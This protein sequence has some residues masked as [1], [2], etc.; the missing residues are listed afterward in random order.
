MFFTSTLTPSAC[1]PAGRIET[2]AS[3]RRLPSSRLPSLTAIARNSAR[4]RLKK[5]AAPALVR[6][7]GWVT[8]SISGTPLR[9]KSRWVARPEPAKPSCSDLPAS[10]SRCTRM[11]RT[12]TVCP[13]DSYSTRPSVASGCSYCEI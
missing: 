10:S 7:S 6:R 13:S 5:S 2:F 11:M 3:Q 8:I 4:S 9:L 12:A 1:V